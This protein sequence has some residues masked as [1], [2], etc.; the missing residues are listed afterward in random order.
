MIKT[1]LDY[2]QETSYDR[3]EMSGHFMDWA[4]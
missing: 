1:C 4:N 3:F 2:H